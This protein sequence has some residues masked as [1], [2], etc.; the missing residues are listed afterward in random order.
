VTRGVRVVNENPHPGAKIRNVLLFRMRCTIITGSRDAGK[1]RTAARLASRFREDGLRVGGVI[2]EAA[3]ENGAKVGYSYHDLS[4]GRRA[5][6][7]RKKPGPVAPGTRAFDFSDAGLDFGSRA[8]RS[9][10]D[11]GADAVI[12]DEIGPLEI[13]GAGL[14][15]AVRDALHRF[16]GHILFTVR[17]SLVEELRA[18]VEPLAESVRITQVGTDE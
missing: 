10:V 1:T 16:G 15:P 6:Y 12:V 7:A 5:E 3:M 17:P 18:R 11:A 4:T 8:I 2:S 9:A 14:W 13:G